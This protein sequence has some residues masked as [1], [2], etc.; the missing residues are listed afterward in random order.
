MGQANQSLPSRKYDLLLSSLPSRIPTSLLVLAGFLVVLIALLYGFFGSE[1]GASLR[2]TGSN[3]SMSRAQGI[4]VSFNQVLG[5]ALSNGIVALSGALLAQYQGF[6]DI[7]MGRCA[8]VIG[9]AAVIIGDAVMPRA[10]KKFF[11]MKMLTVVIGGVIYFFVYQT[12][13]FLGLDTDLLKMLSAIVVAIFLSVPYLKGK[14]SSSHV[15]NKE[16]KKDA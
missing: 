12:V 2:A 3:Q 16:E 1:L 6:A 10:I 9:L 8:I 15:K 7:N 5:L 11:P 14:Y 13:V 4:N